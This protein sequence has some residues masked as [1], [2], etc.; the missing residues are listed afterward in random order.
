MLS[1][2]NSYILSIPHGTACEV[3]CEHKNIYLSIKG[4]QHEALDIL[5][6]EDTRRKVMG[7]YVLSTIGKVTNALVL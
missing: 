1:L 6:H 2:V 3:Q 4:K 5:R 7:D